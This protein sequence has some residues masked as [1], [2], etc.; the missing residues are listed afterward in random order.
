MSIKTPSTIPISLS[1]AIAL[2]GFRYGPVL[3]QGV[4]VR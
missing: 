2:R 1:F 3:L 4:G